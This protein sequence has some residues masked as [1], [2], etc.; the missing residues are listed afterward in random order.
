MKTCTL[1]L[2]AGLTAV[3]TALAADPLLESLQKGL[4]EEEV[5]RDLN[6]AAQAYE[7]A[8]RQ[9]DAQRQAAATAVF[10]LA[11][12][13]R[14]LGR[15]NDAVAQY[16]RL[17]EQFADQAPLAALSRTN[18]ALL[19]PESRDA[20]PSGRLSPAVQRQLEL[21]QQELAL[22]E[23]QIKN[24]QLMVDSGRASRE[25]LLALQRDALALRRQMAE[26]ESRTRPDLLEV[27][28]PRTEGV[29]TSEPPPVDPA[30][31]ES[32]REELK[33]VEQELLAARKR[34]ENGK[35]EAAEVRRVQRELLRLQRKLPENSGRERQI[36]SL[37]E[38]L[39]LCE[40]NL[41]EVRKQIQ[42]G[43]APP[44]AEIGARRELL[45]VQRELAA[46]RRLPATTVTAAAPASPTPATSEEEAEIRRIQAIIRDSPDLVNARNATSPGGTPLHN[47]AAK[48]YLAVAEYLLAN[49]ADVNAVDG[50]RRAPLHL[51]ADA[52]HKRMCE[53]LLAKGADVNAADDTGYTPLHRV[54]ENGYLAVA[55]TLLAAGAT[56]NTKSAT[57][58]GQKQ[59]Q[60]GKAPLHTAAEKGFAAAVDLLLQHAA[61]INAKDD[62]GFT[63]LVCAIQANQPATVRRLLEKGADPNA[64]GTSALLYAVADGREPLVRL[65]LEH[66]A[67][68]EARILAP[69]PQGDWTVLFRALG[70]G[71][72]PGDV[73]MTRLLL[74][75]GAN[76]NARAASGITPV[77]WVAIR[78]A[79]IPSDWSSAFQRNLSASLR[80]LLE[81]QAD[82][83]ARDSGGNTPLH[84]A[85]D[86]GLAEIVEIL[87]A[88]GADPNAPGWNGGEETDWPPLLAAIRQQR[89]P[90]TPTPG[91]PGSAEAR[92]AIVDAL[93][94]HGAAV[95]GRLTY[96]WTALHRAA[97]FN[98]AEMAALLVANKADVNA[99]GSRPEGEPQLG[100]RKAEPAA[101][102]GSLFP[103]SA[104]PRR[105]PPPGMPIVGSPSGQGAEVIPADKD[106][107]P[108][109]VAAANPNLE[110]A[111][112]LLE[113]GA[114][115]NARDAESRAPLH[116]AV[117]RRDLEM[118][119]LLLDAG[120]DPNAKDSTGWTPLC[121]AADLHLIPAAVRAPLGGGGT[122]VQVKPQD[123]I[124]LLRERGAKDDPAVKVEPVVSEPPADRAVSPGFGVARVLGE[125]K[126][127]G[128]VALGP[129]ARK[130]IIDAI[131]ESGGFTENASAA[132]EF[133]RDGQTRKFLWDELKAKS[134]AENKF[135]LQPGDLIEV[136]RGLF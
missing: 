35:A 16:R 32:L 92:A 93:L 103:A 117:K 80:L 102:A 39:A 108:L 70:A 132:I 106:V 49:N 19:A 66:K 54:V 98:Q 77:H 119:R 6:T 31:A 134:D 73:E 33:L 48:G 120:A 135:W 7:A 83:N 67:D 64:H 43:A 72:S 45:A 74:D 91:A 27:P 10:R 44:L 125:V 136:K 12:T 28:L 78:G 22:V 101:R 113:H 63:P 51:A 2:L 24:K 112:F 127:P 99:R 11:E 56:V 123:V 25:D 60:V 76:V 38:E 37:Q 17:L 87:L 9:A 41:A 58:L 47:A 105:G 110:L 111:Q 86:A 36:E 62:E 94:R 59:R 124:A 121:W 26:L 8:V 95:N 118:I 115:V 100:P 21:L 128:T 20:K 4:L 69:E 114:D 52:G 122:Y 18:L 126:R 40:E 71:H 14:K 5:N 79:Q 46:A 53:L 82:V 61:D 109:H 129:G 130:D 96:G 104:L 13:Y 68:L 15:T 29:Q 55:E 34:F 65:L 107:T 81:R 85:V 133:T 57:L 89:Q 97:Q 75:A 116:F 30:E 23:D 50:L 3:L 84:Y 1:N 131:A 90:P 88:A 42:V